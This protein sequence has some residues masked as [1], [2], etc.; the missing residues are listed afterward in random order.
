MNRNKLIRVS[1][2]LL[3]IFLI[4]IIIYTIH[5]Y[6]H[7][8]ST[9]PADWGTFGD[10]VNGLT[11][12]LLAITGVFITYEFNETS[13]E[14]QER[15]FRPLAYINAEDFETRIFVGIKNSG[16]GPLLIKNVLVTNSKGETKINLIDWMPQLPTNITWTNFF[17]N[18]IGYVIQAGEE[19]PL[20]ELS[21]ENL[22]F[23]GTEL[24][25]AP[26]SETILID[27]FSIPR[28][29]VRKAL[30]DLTIELEYEDIYGNQMPSAK[31]KLDWFARN[32]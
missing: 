22:N 23:D 30:A 12:A 31:R 18:P 20:I 19:V 25:D 14:K 27:F 5:F 16:L 24:A 4:P 21:A 10:Y 13:L 3:C 11:G 29:S 17:G 8:W 6:D 9:D 7:E 1:L 2:F 28:D 15:S 32:L 26:L